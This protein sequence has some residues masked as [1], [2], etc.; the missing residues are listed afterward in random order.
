MAVAE[1]GVD[2]RLDVLPAELTVDAGRSRG[3][4]LAA[5]PASRRPSAVLA[6]IDLLAFGALQALLQY[7]IRVPADVS[8]MGYDDIPFAR[9]LSV[10]LTTVSR[11]HYEMGTT[12]AELLTGTLTGR[13]PKH[14]HVLFQPKLVVRESTGRPTTPRRG[15]SR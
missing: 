2:V 4:E 7:E 5:M 1:S 3:E 15:K 12:A 6:A 10:P 9:Q 11:P 13:R 8:L 14:P